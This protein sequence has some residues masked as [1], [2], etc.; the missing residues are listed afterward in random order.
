MGAAQPVRDPIRVSWERSHASQV[1]ID[2]PAPKYFDRID[3]ETTLM[4][5]ARPVIDALSAEL[6]NEPVCIILTDAKGVVLDRRGGDP[7]LLRRLDSVDLAPGFQYVESAVG[8][9]GIGTALEVCGPILVDGPEHYN[10]KLRMF[11]CAGAPITHPVTGG[12]LGVLDITTQARNSNSILLS[13]AK[14]AA[15]RI[16]ERVVEEA[17][18]L[19]H[20][21]L[22]DYYAACRHSG[23]PVLALGDE[24]F[25]MNAYAQARFD[26]I[27]QA[28]LID[29]TRDARGGTKPRVILTDLP[30]GMTARM[31]YRPT[32]LGDTLAGGVIQIKE[33]RPPARSQQPA[34]APLVPG[35]IGSSAVWQ[36]VTQEMLDACRRSE[37]LIADGEPGA[38]KL[39]L[40]RAV[41]KHVAP[42]RRLAVLDPAVT[43][44][45]L[46]AEAQAEL[47]SGSDLIIRR[48]NLLTGEVLHG[49]TDLLQNVRDGAIAGDAWVALTLPADRSELADQL[50]AFFPRTVEVPPLRH[51]L[52]DVPAL[53][54]ALLAKAG[55]SELTFSTP[56]MNQLMRLPWAGNIT[57]L[58]A[59]LSA[60]ARRRRSGVVELGDL[61]PECRATTRRQL[62]P[63]EALERDAI[64]DAMSTYDGDKKAAA[65][66]LGMSRATIYRKIREYGIVT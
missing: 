6:T 56:T 27:D 4:R 45:D 55:V 62:T 34:R 9:N 44:D 66:A 60:V 53:V 52:E 28:A 24:V 61:P 41:R 16:H 15:R 50:L 47:E 46:P 14:L 51:H 59:V 8:T 13:F 32:F 64:V 65:A 35:T 12:L 29:R 54:R 58:R 26:A 5:A 49:L 25:M 37:W 43:G 57:H 63:I 7:A 48:A 11:S 22:S 40:L 20:A 3:R 10:D 1:D 30:S 33:Q 19:D 17:N 2:R 39:S 38:G 42:E 36:H 21:L 18:A 31:A 23:G